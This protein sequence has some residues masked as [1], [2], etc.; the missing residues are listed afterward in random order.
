MLDKFKSTIRSPSI[1]ATKIKMIIIHCMVHLLV[2][3]VILATQKKRREYFS[4]LVIS[5]LLPDV[6]DDDRVLFTL[7]GECHFIMQVCVFSI[8]IRTMYMWSVAGSGF[9]NVKIPTRTTFSSL[10]SSPLI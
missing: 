8:V 6:G 9:L 7:A 4:W 2:Y 5:I 3:V 10:N 1:S